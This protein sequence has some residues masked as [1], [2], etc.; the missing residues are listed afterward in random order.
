MISVD[1][2]EIEK[3]LCEMINSDISILKFL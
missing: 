3:E 1:V 2:L